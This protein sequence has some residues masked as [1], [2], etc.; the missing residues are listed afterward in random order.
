MMPQLR[1]HV[2]VLGHLADRVHVPATEMRADILYLLKLQNETDPKA[3]EGLKKI[4]KEI[5]KSRIKLIETDCNIFEVNNIVKTVKKIMEE[6]YEHHLLFN[7][8]SGNTLS[9]ISFT[10]ASMLY[11]DMVHSIK[12]YYVKYDYDK[13]K[14]NSSKIMGLPAFLIH[15][16]TKKQQEVMSFINSEEEGVT[17][18][19]ILSHIIPDFTSLDRSVKSNK[20]MNL[21]RQIIDK[22]LYKWKMISVDGKGKSS[23]IKLNKNGKEFIQFI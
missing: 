4:R 11:K 12:L 14:V 23:R 17:K 1:I 9:S 20:L 19:Q 6:N 2:S 22:L 13:M 3:I 5:K 15:S 8:S 10:M 16:P 21:N 18:K 7:I